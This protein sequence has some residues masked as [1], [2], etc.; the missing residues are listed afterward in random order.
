[1]PFAGYGSNDN[2]HHISAKRKCETEIKKTKT[3]C[4]LFAGRD[5]AEA[6]F[7]HHSSSVTVLAPTT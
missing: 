4:H 2:N 3:A 7:S 6:R 5:Q 1:M